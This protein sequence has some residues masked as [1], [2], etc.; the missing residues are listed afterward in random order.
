MGVF[1]LVGALGGCLKDKQ[2]DLSPIHVEF[3][4]T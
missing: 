4:G 3:P 1:V 2:R